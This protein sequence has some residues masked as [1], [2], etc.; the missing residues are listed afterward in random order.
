MN[1]HLRVAV[2]ARGRTSTRGVVP[3][4]TEDLGEF[5]A[6]GEWKIGQLLLD[7]GIWHGFTQISSD[8]VLEGGMTWVLAR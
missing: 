7:V 5:L 6:S 2:G 8:W 3:L 1:E 4:G